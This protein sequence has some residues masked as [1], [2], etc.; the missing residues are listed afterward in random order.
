L[1]QLNAVLLLEEIIL[2]YYSRIVPLAELRR[3]CGVSRDG[4]NALNVIKAAKNAE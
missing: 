4:S 1:K 3:E 2:S